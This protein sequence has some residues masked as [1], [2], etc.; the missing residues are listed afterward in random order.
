MKKLMILIAVATLGLAS[1]NKQPS[2]SVDQDSI[3]THYEVYYNK[4]SDKTVAIARFRFGGATGTLLNLEDS[5]YVTYQGDTLV[6]NPFYSGHIKEYAGLNFGGTF[7]YKN[8]DGNVF[9]NNSLPYD[10]I[11]FPASFDTLVKSQAYDLVWDG[12]ALGANER[13]GIFIGSAWAWGQDALLLQ[14]NQGTNNVI[15]GTNN[16]SNLATGPSNCH[17][18]RVNEVF[19]VNGTSQGGKIISKYKAL[20]QGIVVVD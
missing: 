2:N 19:T 14:T 1:C 4:N 15:I 18:E 10:S 16:M 3:Y 6:Y 9:T 11:A 12:S 8:N 17:M 7:E 20:N 13:V 5:A